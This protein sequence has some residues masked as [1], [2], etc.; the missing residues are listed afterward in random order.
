MV[1]VVGVVGFVGLLDV[2]E[3]GLVGELTTGSPVSV[4]GLALTQPIAS[5]GISRTTRS[6]NRMAKLKREHPERDWMHDVQRVCP[7]IL[8]GRA[9]FRI[10]MSCSPVGTTS[11]R[12]HQKIISESHDSTHCLR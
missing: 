6:V 7:G 1:G 2:G 10:A 8:E 9:R 3:L 12:G 4:G 11:A 5:G